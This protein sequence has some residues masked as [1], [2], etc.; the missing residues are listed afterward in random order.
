MG[1]SEGNKGWIRLWGYEGGNGI[2]PGGKLVL[3]G[4]LSLS[5]PSQ[6]GAATSAQTQREREFPKIGGEEMRLGKEKIPL[7]I[8]R[9]PGGQ[10]TRGIKKEQQKIPK[11][12]KLEPNQQQQLHCPP[13]VLFLGTR[14]D[15]IPLFLGMGF[16]GFEGL[17][18]N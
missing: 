5:V 9:T 8:I 11:I 15:A 13:R 12:P 17:L 4:I 16:P 6:V 1:I 2:S 18:L 14:M 10:N 7:G 3:L